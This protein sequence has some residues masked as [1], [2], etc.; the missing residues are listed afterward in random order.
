[1]PRPGSGLC[2]CM[3]VGSCVRVCLHAHCLPGTCVLCICVS[4]V[5]HCLE[6]FCC[7]EWVSKQQI[8]SSG[9]LDS[10]S[11]SH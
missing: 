10:F 6:G 1:M 5:L 4:V 9:L 7:G 2:L 3:F 8:V 11:S